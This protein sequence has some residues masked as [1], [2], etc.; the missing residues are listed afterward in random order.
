MGQHVDWSQVESLDPGKPETTLDIFGILW[1]R[2]WIVACVMVI[3]LALSYL[4]YLQ[5]TRVYRSM[6]QVLLVKK[7]P[8]I[9][10][11]E[12]PIDSNPRV[13]PYSGY[14]PDAG[15]YR[16]SQGDPRRRS[17]YSRSERHRIVV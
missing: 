17:Q 1:R 5:A 16:G 13:G 12:R 2:K 4:Y 7:S 3:A 6:A 9:P 10:I 14:E 8:T 15:H 11:T